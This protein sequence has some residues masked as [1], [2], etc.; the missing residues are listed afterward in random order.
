MIQALVFD[1][2]GLILDTETPEFHSWQNIYREYGFEFPNERWGSI[3]GGNG[4]DSDFDAAEHLSSLTQGR[5]ESDFLRG[6]NRLES[7]RII[8]ASKPMPGVMDYLHEAKR[9]GLRLAIASSSDHAWVDTHAKRIGV[10]DYF[11]V[12]IAAEDVGPGRTKPNPD[13]FLTAL[14]RLRVPKEAAIVFEDSPNGVKA[15]NRADIFVVAVPNGVTSLL[16]LDGADLILKS[17]ADMPLSQL[18]D[19]IESNHGRAR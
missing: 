2:D 4:H 15:A 1:F 17:L 10:Y 13:L 16:S 5:L 18:L 11:D 8:L 9:F 6:R 7:D 19:T 12:V 14:R 3:V